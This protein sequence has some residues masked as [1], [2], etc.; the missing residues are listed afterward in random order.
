MEAKCRNVNLQKRGF[1]RGIFRTTS[2]TYYAK[3]DP[4]FF[5]CKK[6]IKQV[7]YI[8]INPEGKHITWFVKTDDCTAREL[9]QETQKFCRD[10]AVNSETYFPIKSGMTR[11]LEYSY[12]ISSAREEMEMLRTNIGKLI[13]S[14]MMLQKKIDDSLMYKS[15][16]QSI[17]MHETNFLT[18]V[19]HGDSSF[20]LITKNLNEDDDILKMVS[21]RE[22]D[23]VKLQCFMSC[24]DKWIK[25]AYRTYSGI[26]LDK[27]FVEYISSKI[28]LK[29]SVG[30]T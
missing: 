30:L 7:R 24:K 5:G 18:N 29:K 4:Q 25:G 14:E 12:S 16:L 10:N 8:S 6:Y 21:Q 23:T 2:G 3:F 13:A 26:N 20:A 28:D 19:L 27:T 22:I 17:K 1:A 15:V 9:V 11:N